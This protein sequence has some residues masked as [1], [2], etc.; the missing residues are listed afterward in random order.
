MTDREE[1]K[2]QI[3]TELKKLE[4]EKDLTESPE[5]H[6][7][8]MD[9]EQK[10]QVDPFLDEAIKM[11]FNPNYQ[12]PNKKTAEQFVRDGSFFRKI[13]DLKKR[14]DDQTKAMELLV[15]HNKKKELD[16]YK[17]GIEDAMARRREAVELGDVDK[18][19]AA[20]RD[21]QELQRSKVE[22]TPSVETQKPTVSQ[23]MLDFVEKNKSWFNNSTK[24]NERMVMEADGL[25]TL[26]SKYNP[27]LSEKEILD[28]VLTKVK[29]LHPDKFEN[30]NKEKPKAVATS[31]VSGGSKDPLDSQL[32]ERQKRVFA[33]AKA[34]D[35]SLKIEDYIKNRREA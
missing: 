16:A 29:A 20:E 27:H 6:S 5:V 21:I 23:D 12:G 24:E 19:N 9:S 8:T 7:E 15:E 13:D 4:P 35:P 14:I 18:F 1:L 22:P 34:I 26:E 30:P 17:K 33:M 32:T 25:F 31:S 11:G 3:D 10:D 2:Q 28:I